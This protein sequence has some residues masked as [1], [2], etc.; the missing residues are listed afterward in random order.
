MVFGFK[1]SVLL[2][3][4][5]DVKN[6]LGLTLNHWTIV[7]WSIYCAFTIFEAYDLKYKILPKWLRSIKTY[8]YGIMMMIGIGTSF[9]LGVITI[10]DSINTIYGYHIPSYALVVLLGG[11]VTISLMLGVHKGMKNFAKFAMWLLF[12]FMLIMVIVAPK[13]TLTVGISGVMSLF[14][15]F[16]YNNIYTGRAVQNDWTNFY[17]VWWI[18]WAAFVAPFIINISKGR[19]I[20]SIVFY[21]LIVPS[22][23]IIVYMILGSSIGL[24]LMAKGVSSDMIPF[25]SIQFHWLMPLLFVLLMVMFYVT[26]SDSQSYA[27]DCLVSKGSKTPV[28]YRKILWVFL[29]VLFVTVLL[30]AGSGTTSS[31]QGLGFLGSPL[32]IIFGLINIVLII[33]H[34]Y[35][36]YKTNKK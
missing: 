26:S 21:T 12:T 33:K 20:R 14:S 28:V 4:Y 29:E 35:K 8:L 13:N 2:S 36:T 10:S 32:L 16:F 6:P 24:D 30:L 3:E 23:L 7:P 18:G 25:K 34:L 19:S 5:P 17:D 22:I 11:A 1:E 27:L 31:I 15:D 9:A